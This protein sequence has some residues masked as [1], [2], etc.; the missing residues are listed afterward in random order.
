MTT[1]MRLLMLVSL[2]GVMSSAEARIYVLTYN[3]SNQTE[4]FGIFGQRP[5]AEID[6]C[7][8]VRSG[9]FSVDRTNQ[10]AYF[11]HTTA[12]GDRLRGLR[13]SDGATVQDR[14]VPANIEIVLMR[15][16]SVAGTLYALAKDN[17]TGPRLNLIRILPGLGSFTTIGTGIRECCGVVVG[18]GDIRGTSRQFHFIGHYDP[19]SGQADPELRLFTLDLTSGTLV[20]DSQLPSGIGVSSL[21]VNPATQTLYAWTYNYANAESALATVNPAN[22]A[23]TP[24]TTA[25]D[26]N[27]C[28]AGAGLL[29]ADPATSLGL[30]YLDDSVDGNRFIQVTLATGA[31]GTETQAET[32]IAQHG[33][34]AIALPSIGPML[35]N[36]G[37]GPVV[38]AAR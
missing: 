36:D 19:E 20:S 23:I 27:C 35:F 9:T 7:C 2:L 15:G 37:F 17:S 31:P 8:E 38:Q 28:A 29:V 16:D 18:A 13:L 34:I 11:I 25:V 3:P 6:G 12:G 33:L 1:P 5:L 24:L 22:A 10:V 26:P 4:S 14:A 30:N 21:S 32:G